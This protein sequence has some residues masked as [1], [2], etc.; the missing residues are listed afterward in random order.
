MQP[1]KATPAAL[2]LLEEI[3]AEAGEVLFHLSGGCCDGTA[4]MC[5][6]V[7]DFALGP[8]DQCLGQVAGAGVWVSAGLAPLWR[9]ARPH[10]D[11]VPGRAGG[12]S[13][14]GG[15]GRRFLLGTEICA[16]G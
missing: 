8:G 4:A 6:A 16:R 9:D 12:F 13:L 11:A 5:F 7:A 10:L 15:R 2:A 1:I 3:R 14:D